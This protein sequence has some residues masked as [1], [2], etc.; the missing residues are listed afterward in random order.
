MEQEL[1]PRQQV[2]L[3]TSVD[4]I[5]AIL[6]RYKGRAC[7][8]LGFDGGVRQTAYVRRRVENYEKYAML[9]FSS[10]SKTVF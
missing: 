3:C 1:N 10:V 7:T 4:V 5:G 9:R 6:P 2:K 8:S